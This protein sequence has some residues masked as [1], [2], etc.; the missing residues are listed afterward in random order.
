M[1]ILK[2]RCPECNAGLKSPT[3][4]TVGQTVCCPKCE[5]YFS[6]KEPEE[7]RD[8]EEDE[9]PKKGAKKTVK[10]S[11]ADDDGDDGDS[12]KTKKK[13]RAYDEDEEPTRS[14]KNSPLRYAV[15]GILVVVMLVLGYMLY[16]KWKTEREVAK[17]NEA[18]GNNTPNPQFQQ[19]PPLVP[20]NVRPGPGPGPIGPIP[21]P[22]GPKGKQPTGKAPE[23]P[24]PLGGFEGA[25][26]TPAQIAKFKTDLV[27]TWAADLGNGA[28]EELTYTASGTFTSKLTGPMPAMA[29]GKYMVTGAVTTKVF[30]VQ[31]DTSAGPRTITV[32]IEDNELLHPS[33]QPGVTGTF[34]KK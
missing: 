23:L 31:L 12:P 32:T 34:R 3:G 9:T 11:A 2:T 8:D 25:A 4:F 21:N 18:S 17:A 20:N 29:S 1:A 15:L 27:G 28:T 10:A 7:E 6:V 30:K 19:P 24:N 33:L 13:K 22:K 26:A 5:T 16:D 14:Y